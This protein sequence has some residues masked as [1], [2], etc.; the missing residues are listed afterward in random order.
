MFH[1]LCSPRQEERWWFVC[2]C[3]LSSTYSIL[4]PN[5]VLFSSPS[6]A[7]LEISLTL[8]LCIN[9]SLGCSALTSHTSNCPGLPPRNPVS[10]PNLWTRRVSPCHLS[11]FRLVWLSLPWGLMEKLPQ[12]SANSVLPTECSIFNLHP[13]T[14][15][16]SA[17][18]LLLIFCTNLWER[19]LWPE[20]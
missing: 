11:T 6:F 18:A 20:P 4:A 7:W 1:L 2:L 17:E 19:E 10:C 16:A 3:W 13:F 14:L 15:R 9:D 12:K 5:K 8:D